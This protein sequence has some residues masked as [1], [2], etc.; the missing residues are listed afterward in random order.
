MNEE[1]A[2]HC[3]HGLWAG[4]QAERRDLAHLRCTC[5]GRAAGLQ[6]GWYPRG[7][8]TPTR[9]CR[10]CPA[11]RNGAAVAGTLPCSPVAPGSPTPRAVQK[12]LCHSRSPALL[13]LPVG[14]A[15]TFLWGS[16]A[17]LPFTWRSP[18][19]KPQARSAV[20]ALGVWAGAAGPVSLSAHVQH[21]HWPVF[22]RPVVRR[23]GRSVTLG[24]AVPSKRASPHFSAPPS[25]AFSRP[26]NENHTV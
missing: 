7:P 15:A 18:G 26:S 14:L 4:S 19:G 3:A 5:Q 12:L 25:Q 11:G 6:G 2:L 13:S 23:R 24:S 17:C 8:L 20:G 9:G 21:C 1:S 16:D 22:T 10:C